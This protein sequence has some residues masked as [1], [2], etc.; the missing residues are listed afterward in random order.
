MLITVFIVALLSAVV[1]GI[2]QMVTEELQIM[3]N[4]SFAV[5]ALNVA[6]AG[7]NDAFAQIR[8]DSSWTAGFTNK[9]F[10]TDIYT[11]TVAGA[12]PDITIESTATTSQSFVA[13]VTADITVSKNAPYVIRINNLRINE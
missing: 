13:K 11:V 7:L 2:L 9:A 6:E 1:I 8:A 3:R 5:Q 10:N 12:L 4:N